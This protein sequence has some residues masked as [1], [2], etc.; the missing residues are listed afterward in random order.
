[1]TN[2]RKIEWQLPGRRGRADHAVTRKMCELKSIKKL[3]GGNDLDLAKAL[4]GKKIAPITGNNHLAVAF[5][6][7]L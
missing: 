1:M 5:D 2:F 7:T 6:G 4:Q 3:A